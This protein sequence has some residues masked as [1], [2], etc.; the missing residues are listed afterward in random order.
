MRR[1]FNT[2]GPTFP[3]KHYSIPP[4]SRIDLP[5]IWDL[6]DREKYFILHAPWQ[7]GKTTC[8]LALRDY[9]GV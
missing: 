5:S 1:F 9:W 6:I 8:L 2:E 7:T 4:L 3:T